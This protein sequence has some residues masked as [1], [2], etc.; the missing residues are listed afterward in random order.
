MEEKKHWKSRMEHLSGVSLQAIEDHYSEIDKTEG[1]FSTATQVFPTGQHN[2]KDGK[3]ERT[4]DAIS[5][6]KVR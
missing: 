6:I 4:Y 1:K 3:E 5:Y 2:I